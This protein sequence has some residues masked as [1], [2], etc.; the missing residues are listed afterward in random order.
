[1]HSRYRS[2][3]HKE[4][5]VA[6]PGLVPCLTEWQSTQPGARVGGVLQRVRRIGTATLVLWSVILSWPREIQGQ[7]GL[8]SGEARVALIAIAPAH[9]SLEAVSP[10]RE[11]ASPASLR[12]ESVTLRLSSN[13]GYRLIVRRM[14]TYTAGSVGRVWVRAADGNFHELAPGS[15]VTIAEDRLAGQ[16]EREV[17]YRIEGLP[18]SPATLQGLP[19]HYDIVVKPVI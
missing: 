4:I 16:D 14:G 18:P 9:A 5:C 13:N 12:E 10:P 7:V 1:M 8:A 11:A 19:V 17:L 2:L 3:R 6:S 15:P